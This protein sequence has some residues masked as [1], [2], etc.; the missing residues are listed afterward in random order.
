MRMISGRDAHKHPEVFEQIFKLRH[1]V[2]VRE[3]GWEDLA[4]PD[5][6]EIDQFDTHDA[7]HLVSEQDGIVVGYIRALPTTKPHLLT[8]VLP[9]LCQV[10]TSPC[11]ENVWEM[12][13]YCVHPDYRRG[14]WSQGSTGSEVIAGTVEWAIQSGVNKL[15]FEFEPNWVLRAMQLQFLVRPLGLLHKIGHQYVVA[16][17]LTLTDGTLQTIRQNREVDRPVLKAA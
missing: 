8:D 7:V 5:G 11:G 15:V 16:A 6:L 9:Q 13:R 2:F 17:E 1:H 12:S 10:E 4:S 14:R 3:M